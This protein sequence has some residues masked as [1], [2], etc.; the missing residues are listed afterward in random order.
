MHPLMNKR[1]SGRILIQLLVLLFLCNTAFPGV[2]PAKT[3]SI[4]TPEGLK[5]PSAPVNSSL[6]FPWAGGLNSCQFVTIDLNLDGVDDL[7]I[8]DRHGNRKLT[9]LTNTADAVSDYLFAPEYAAALPEITDWIITADYNCDGLMD[10]F[11][12]NDG[13]VRIFRNI[14]ADTLKFQLVT[15]L[16]E[17]YYYGGKV[18]VLVTSVDYPAFSDIDGDGDL[19]LLTFFGLGSYVEFHKNLSMEKYGN[20]DSLDYRL[21]DPC[22]GK[23]RESESGNKITLN[24]QCPYAENPG[25]PIKEHEF[26]SRAVMATGSGIRAADGL[27]HT[28]S[29][30]LA[31]DLNGDGLKDLILGD[32][33]YP[34][35]IALYNGGTRDSAFMVSADTLF[36]VSSRAVK[37]FSFPDAS[38]IDIDRDGV[39]D[40][41]CSPFD[42]ASFSSDNYNCVWFYKNL[43]TNDHPQ[44]EFVT[45]RLFR[46]QMM[47]FGTASHPVLYDFDH[48]G[49]TDLLV[50]ND[51][52][53]DSSYYYEGVLH[54]VYTSAIS[55]FRNTG[56][57][58]EPVFTHIT[59]DLAK[60]HELMTRGLFPACGD[61]NGDGL[62]DLL[63]GDADGTL[64]LFLNT[65]SAG[66]IPEFAPPVKKFQAIDVGDYS[67]PQLFDLDKDGKDELIIGSRGGTL[68]LYRNGGSAVAPLFVKVTDS[69]GSVNV[70]NYLISWDGFNTPCFFRTNDGSTRLVTGSDDG[71]IHLY[72]QIDGNLDGAFREIPGLYD[73]ISAS[74]SDSL[75]GWQTSP[76]LAPLRGPAAFD[77]IT[78]NFSGGLNYL[79]KL[80]PAPIIPGI[81]D[82]EPDQ[83]AV[84]HIHPN[85]AD[86][87]VN[88]SI[89]P[90]YSGAASADIS[91]SNAS[92]PFSGQSGSSFSSNQLS[93]P[94]KL[95]ILGMYDFLGRK[96]AE[97]RFTTSLT[98]PTAELRDG[99]YLLRCGTLLEKLIIRHP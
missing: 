71:R 1:F 70:T 96:I 99:I 75:F 27:R 26:A 68:T 55:L 39:K 58:T 93:G 4:H 79:S 92:V 8:F 84:M 10:I 30:L 16:L 65:G 6:E 47:D 40:L 73:W 17:S 24:V 89:Q 31:T 50:G 2:F 80:S 98:I 91:A 34:G 41:V 42:P 3:Q 62:T 81:N 90:G 72:D 21:T 23:F 33:D 60:A 18:G 78:G 22:W 12:Y 86:Q 49:L 5:S 74:P 32:Y 14:S 51:G 25:T 52:Y 97:Y 11:T 94:D 28:G 54:S 35:L 59:D 48:D 69:L 29:T 82:Q 61:L 56:T 85:P 83:K 57:S 95:L 20:C 7:L 64:T 45:D 15:D 76:T 38:L 44:F 88:I 36:P 87:S 43:G 13:G 53:Y 63:T 46:S 67:A 9:F 77:M 66:T 37:L 19:D